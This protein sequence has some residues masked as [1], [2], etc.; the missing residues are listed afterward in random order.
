M[1]EDT[2]SPNPVRTILFDLTAVQPIGVSKRHGGG[3]Y[4]E[5]VFKRIVERGLDVACFYDGRKWIN[6]EICK[7]IEDNKIKL[8][9]VSKESLQEIVDK[10][11]YSIIYSALPTKSLMQ[12]E[13]IKIVGTIHGLRRLET[14]ADSYCLRYKNVS[15]KDLMFFFS[16]ILFKK[17]ITK[18]LCEYYLQS[19]KKDNCQF[20]TVSNHTSNAIKFFLPELKHKNIP[21]FY[22]PSTSSS[23]VFDK[24]YQEKYFLLV[25][26]NRCEK[27]NLRAIMAFDKL[28]T[29]GYLQDYKVKIT[30]AK[31][32][33]N[34]RYKIKNLSRFEFLG[35][36]DDQE[37][38][39]LY[40]DAYCLVYPSLNEGFGYP[41][42]EAMHYGVPVLASSYS[43]IS[44][45]CQGAAMYFNPFAI[46][47][48]ANRVLQITDESVHRQYS[49]LARSQYVKI[50]DKQNSD[51]DKMV[52]YLYSL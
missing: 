19:W 38:K 4:G 26:G 12:I 27:N 30:G 51:L 29:L 13:G 34:F 11:S 10:N 33:S 31:D 2:N 18:K 20:V 21:V 5:I 40:N 25:S 42:L 3:I 52:D 32:S 8:Y 7:I 41:P 47:E 35:Y 16:K 6:P 36:V 15:K 28:F 22:S 23:E 39:Q 9:D 46:E 1:K 17:R 24:K 44:E 50:T 49:A 43:S 14:P 45:V 37:L 48:I